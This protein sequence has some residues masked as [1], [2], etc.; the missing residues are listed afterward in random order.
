MNFAFFDSLSRSE[1][2]DYLSRFL[3]EASEGLT[4]TADAAR[5]DGLMIDYSLG[6]L[7]TFAMWVLPRLQTTPRAP[8]LSL[9]D[10]IR[11]TKEYT[12]GLFDFTESSR[13]LV[14]RTAFYFGETFVRTFPHLRWG[15]GDEDSALRHM[16]VIRNFNRSLELAPLLVVENLFT[17]VIAE[18]SQRHSFADA[19]QHWIVHAEV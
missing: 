12:D 7:G 8:N 11:Q 6:S 5:S 13:I 4:E 19:I 15:T 1:A 3:L 2:E 10:W 9:P 17:R 14:L 16:P 18:P